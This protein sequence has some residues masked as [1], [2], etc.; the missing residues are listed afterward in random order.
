M[1]E[2][3][4]Q[5]LLAAHGMRGISGY[6]NLD[7]AVLVV[8]YIEVYVREEG[9]PAE[10]MHGAFTSQQQLH[11]LRKSPCQPDNATLQHKGTAAQRQ[12]L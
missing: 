3:C 8:G 4:A 12:H 1:L 9:Y 5:A 2:H 7:H 11:T 10:G 6:V